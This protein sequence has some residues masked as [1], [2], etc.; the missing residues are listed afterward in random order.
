LLPAIYAI[1]ISVWVKVLALAQE[2]HLVQVRA[3]IG[4]TVAQ[5]QCGRMPTLPK[6]VERRDGCLATGCVN[7]RDRCLHLRQKVVQ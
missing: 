1:T 4:E 7:R 6:A 5:I 3:R 2:S